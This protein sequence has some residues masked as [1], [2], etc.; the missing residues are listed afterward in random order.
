LDKE[1]NKAMDLLDIVHRQIVPEPWAEGEKIPWNDPDF[2]QRML[3]E[4]LSQDHDAAS[5][6]TELIDQHV[7]WLHR[8]VLSGKATKILDLG[9]G[10]GLY[11]SRLAKLGHVCVGI[12]FS[13]ASIAYAQKQAEKEKLRCNYVHKD[14]R[15]AD[16]GTGY[17]LAMFIFGE[18]NVFKPADARLILRKAHAALAEDG[19]LVLEPHKFSSLRS[20]EAQ[21]T[22]WYSTKSGLF[23]EKPHICL[24]ECFWNADRQATTERYIIIDAVSGK[25]TWHAASMQAYSD[26]QYESL[27]TECGFAEVRFYPSLKGGEDESQPDLMAIVARKQADAQ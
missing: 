23:S 21:A 2:S 18:F 7:E 17:G 4:H 12:D 22:S 10:P 11:A 14:I 19:L 9:C 27:L 13:P 15:A 5:R 16:F 8:E 25:V 3:E 6:R 26:A 24:Y 20:K 1:E